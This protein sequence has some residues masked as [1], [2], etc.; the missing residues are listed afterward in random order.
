VFNETNADE[1]RADL[2]AWL[3]SRLQGAT[4]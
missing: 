4:A 1:V 2:I 3:E